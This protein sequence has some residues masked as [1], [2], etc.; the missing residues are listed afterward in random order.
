MFHTL[1][2]PK[3]T[4]LALFILHTLMVSM[5]CLTD[6]TSLKMFDIAQWGLGMDHT[7]P[8]EWIPPTNPKAVRG[9]KMIYE[10][11]IEMVHEDFGRGWGVRF[12]GTKGALDVS[13]Q[14]LDS[15]PENIVSAE[16]KNTLS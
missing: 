12:I 16:I 14:Y 10:N 6:S 2:V 7:G 11:G 15:N 5:L 13:R 9:L 1:A 4:F 3:Q 8:V